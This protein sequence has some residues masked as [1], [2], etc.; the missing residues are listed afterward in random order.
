VRKHNA[1]WAAS[2]YFALM[3][4]TTI[5]TFLRSG[6]AEL[7]SRMN[8]PP[9]EMEVLAGVPL[10]GSHLAIFF[11]VPLVATLGLIL[12]SKRH[13]VPDPAPNR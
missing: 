7:L 13:F 2:I 10:R 3:A 5:L 12:L 11:G 8:F 1:M 6:F 4:S 9:T